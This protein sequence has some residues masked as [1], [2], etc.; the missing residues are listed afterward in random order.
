MGWGLQVK[1]IIIGLTMRLN[2]LFRKSTDSARV[3]FFSLSLSLY[4]KVK[5]IIL[6][7]IFCICEE[8][9]S[10]KCCIWCISHKLIH[11]IIEISFFS[12]HP[13]PEKVISLSLDS[14]P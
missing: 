10:V 7:E 5:T 3:F 8:G 13:F 12:F 14:G 6:I 9:E 11:L 2:L 1:P 4:G